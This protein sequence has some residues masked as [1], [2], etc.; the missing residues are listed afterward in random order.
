MDRSG[1]W[2]GG[3][4][5]RTK[6]RRAASRARAWEPEE[7]CIGPSRA[8]IADVVLLST[9]AKWMEKVVNNHFTFDAHSHG[10]LHPLQ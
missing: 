8:T 5:S 4:V 2:R 7:A 3:P 9:I 10:I 6:A 1:A